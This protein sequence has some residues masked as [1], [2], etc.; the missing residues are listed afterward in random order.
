MI[1]IATSDDSKAISDIY[2]YY[3][4]NSHS[5]FETEP[6]SVEE[7]G[8]RIERVT[9]EFQLPWLVFE[10]DGKI[11]GYTYATQWKPRAAYEKTVETT[12]YLHQEEFGKGIGSQLYIGLL[13]Q[14]ENSGYHAILGGIAQPNEASI[15]LHEKLGFVKVGQLKEVGLKFNKWVDVGYWQLIFSEK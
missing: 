11:A 4:L 1:R 8:Q 15:A 6:V 5:T 13:E 10:I 2:N 9:R 14:L 3:V 7:M 12:V